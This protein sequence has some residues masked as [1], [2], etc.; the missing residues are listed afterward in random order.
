MSG[1][2]RLFVA[3]AIAMMVVT[4]ACASPAVTP[5]TK[6]TPTATRSLEPTPTTAPSSTL[7]PAVTPLVTAPPTAKPDLLLSNGTLGEGFKIVLVEHLTCDAPICDPSQPVIDI[8]MFEQTKGTFKDLTDSYGAE[9]AVRV[10]INGCAGGIGNAL[11]F[12]HADLGMVDVEFAEV[13]M[14]GCGTLTLHFFD[15][16]PV[17]IPD[18]YGL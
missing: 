5:N 12:G 8:T 17:T 7:V 3:A 10:Y 2:K 11:A 14:A 13:D 4:S 6:P 15:Y 18:R 16:S 1:A 9:S